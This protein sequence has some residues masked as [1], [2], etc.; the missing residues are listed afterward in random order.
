VLSEI[1]EAFNASYH[2][3]ET[4]GYYN[5]R[6]IAAALVSFFYLLVFIAALIIFFSR[7]FVEQLVELGYIKRTATYV[8]LLLGKW[9][10]IIGLTFFFISFLYYLA[11]QRKTKW[12]FFFRQDRCL[13]PF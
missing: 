9:I 13:L 8:M 5:Q 7:N 2:A 6:L 12:R 11:P 3:I 4:R 10:V 1:I